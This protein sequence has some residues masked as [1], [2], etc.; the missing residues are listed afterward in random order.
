MKPETKFRIKVVAFLRTFNGI[1][2][3]SIQQ[4][5]IVGTPDIIG[6]I[7]GRFFAVEVKSALGTAS[8]I[9]KYKLENIK[10]AGG[11]SFIVAPQTFEDFKTD[12]SD[13]YYSLRLLQK[14]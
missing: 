9:Q 7:L 11:L 6:C 5:T 14:S 2:F 13:Q 4:Q 12:F 1:W 8:V 10:K 3:E